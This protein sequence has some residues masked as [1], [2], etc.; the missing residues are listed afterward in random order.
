MYLGN[1]EGTVQRQDRYLIKILL[2]ASKKAITRSWYKVD[3]PRKEQ[4]FEVIQDIYIMERMTYQL[5]LRGHTHDKNWRKWTTYM[6][7]ENNK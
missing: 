6:E 7:S 5:K 2:I 1:I 4:W 3:P